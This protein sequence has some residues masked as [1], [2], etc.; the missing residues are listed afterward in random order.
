MVRVDHA[1]VRERHR[2][3]G[4][5]PGQHPI[6]R[7]RKAR[8]RPLYFGRGG[9]RDRGPAGGAA[10]AAGDVRPDPGRDHPRQVRW[11]SSRGS[12]TSSTSR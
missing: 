6:P 9:D 8:H 12:T 5:Q 7:S 2:Q 3:P 11:A 4:V 10:A 1:G